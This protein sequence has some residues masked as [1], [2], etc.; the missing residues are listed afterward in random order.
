MTAKVEAP[1]IARL[2]FKGVSGRHRAVVEA[3]ESG[4]VAGL[5]FVDP[6][7]APAS[8]GHWRLLVSEGAAVDAGTA[9]VEIIGE[10]HELGVAEDYV[11]GP[12]GFASGIATRAAAFRA[13]APDGLSLACGGWKKL[14]APLKPMLRAGLAAAGLLPRLVEGDFV[15]MSKN[16]VTLLGGVA[17]AIRAGMVVGHGPVAVQVKSVE[18]ALYAYAAGGRIIMVDTGVI[19]DL[20]AVHCA[21][22]KAGHRA[23]VH[24]AFGGGVRLEDLASVRQAGANAADIGRAILD[25][26]LLD[27]RLRVEESRL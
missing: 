6:A 12:I 20:A 5:G 14:P 13:A 27:L 15:Y 22:I 7:L 10:A 16:A 2:L 8:A 11:L 23:N 25:A 17:P 1:D 21:L 26:P 9:L 18:E 19:A 3:T 4:L 24:L